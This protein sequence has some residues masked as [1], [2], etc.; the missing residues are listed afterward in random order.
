MA[1]K[2]RKL[3]PKEGRPTG[4]SPCKE[5][6]AKKSPVRPTPVKERQK[7]QQKQSE[8]G[9][10]VLEEP[11][12]SEMARWIKLSIKSLTISRADRSWAAEV[13]ND[14]RD[15]LLKFL[16]SCT[17]QP[18]FQAAEFINTGSYFEKVKINNPDEFDMMLKL[19]APTLLTMTELDGGLFYRLDLNRPTRDPIQAFL[20]ENKLTISSS[21][22]LSE[23][24]RLVRKFLKTYKVSDKR[25]RWEVNRKRPNSPAV[26]LSLC[27][28]QNNSEELI[29]VDVVPALM[30]K[31]T[32]G[33][34]HAARNGPNVGN[35]LG[36]KTWQEIKSSSCFFVPKR[37]KGGNIGEDAK[38]SW[39]ISFSLIEKKIITCHGNSKT[40]CENN[41]SK[42]C[43]KQCLMLL[44]SLIEGLKLRF[45]KELD[46]L[47][48]YHGK[49]IF[50]HTLSIRFSDTMWAREQL[51]TCFMDLLCAFE[52]H[53][54]RR[55]LPH[56][57]VPECNL[58]SSA[59]ISRKALTFL[60]GALD[61]QKRTGLPLLMPP[62]PVKP[63]TPP[64]G[65]RP[66]IAEPTAHSLQ[67][68]LINKLILVFAVVVI[69]AL[70]LV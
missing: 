46:G 17:D 47:C 55:V 16:R 41:G 25:C 64:A 10:P 4:A 65:T 50:L 48:S 57:F 11:V 22:I 12:S 29:S 8:E 70:F 24:Y 18:F 2:D 68:G 7:V 60:A 15:N 67:P 5:N 45:P 30:V 31:S 35:W 36:K 69:C 49:T 63:L 52:D 21:K 54:R 51:P 38:E 37:L 34:P 14:F 44:K 26:T 3:N 42:C 28:T 32:Q 33:W 62:A 6:K 20:L 19:Q 58:F 1:G 61:E 27:R 39:R 23:M 13:V 53:V 56:F 59:C 40:C 43:R 66:S 9:P